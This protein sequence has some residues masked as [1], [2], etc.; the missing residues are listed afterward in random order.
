MIHKDIKA[1]NVLLDS[2]LNARLSDFGLA[3]LYK[4]DTNPST[5]RVVGTLGYLAP[6][7]THT[8]KPTKS[9][10]VLAFGALLQEVVCGRRP[11]ELK[12]CLR[13]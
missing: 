5:T 12:H 13:S 8:G 2:E 10:D 1:G 9:I 11:I 6:K 7:L 4:R 3:K